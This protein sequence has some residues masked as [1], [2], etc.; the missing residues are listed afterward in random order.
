M[1]LRQNKKLMLVGAL[2]I[3]LNVSSCSK[4]EDGPMFSLKTK[5]SRL[6]SVDW[7]VVEM[8]NNDISQGTKVILD[9]DKDGD[10][11][12]SYSYPSEYGG[13]YSYS[14]HGEWEWEDGKSSIQV[15]I[16]GESVEWEILRLTKDEFWFEDEEKNEWVCEAE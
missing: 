3:L 7:E 9:F 10:F 8:G 1:N 4:Y 14:I 11:T 5:I 15:E 6:T 16:E 2:A 13:N 12:F